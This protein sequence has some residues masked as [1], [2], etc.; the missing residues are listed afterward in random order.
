MKVHVSSRKSEEVAS[1]TQD[2]VVGRAESR[3]TRVQGTKTSWVGWGQK[4]K[5][6]EQLGIQVSDRGLEKPRNPG[7]GLGEE[8][9]WR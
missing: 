2:T 8:Q 9:M 6:E 3:P 1:C 4:G 5:P 7:L